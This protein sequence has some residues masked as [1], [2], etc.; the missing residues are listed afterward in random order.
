[1]SNTVMEKNS[2]TKDS[3]KS[4]IGSFALSV[5]IHGSVLF[6]V[7]GYVIF[8]GVLPKTPF[9]PVDG[10]SS[11]DFDES[12][13][14]EPSEI[15]DTMESPV[16]TDELSTE[17]TSQSQGEATSSDILVSTSPNNPSF[18]LS[19]AVGAPSYVPKIGFGGGGEKNTSTAT[20]PAPGK[21]IRSLFGTSEVTP[22][23]LVGSFFDIGR[24][25]KGRSRSR[26]E[27][28]AL[29]GRLAE[30]LV[31]ERGNSKVFDDV[32][33]STRKLY[34]SQFLFPRA[35]TAGAYEAFGEKPLTD[36]AS[37][38]VHYSARV[39]PPESGRYRFSGF[40]DDYVIVL[41]DGRPS[42]I[43]DNLV[44]ENNP[45]NAKLKS[46][47]RHFDWESPVDLFP[48]RWNKFCRYTMGDW[49]DW[50]KDETKRLDIFIGDSFGQFVAFVGI[51]Q[52]GKKYEQ[53]AD[54]VPI[55]PPFR[56][57]KQ[58]VDREEFTALL[59]EG[60]DFQE[61][62]GPVFISK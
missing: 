45:E 20:A 58:K 32:Y 2:P 26:D 35:T 62:G 34:A 49:I 41:V 56:L 21:V 22:N 15:P 33:E 61:R 31:K 54:G 30:E 19:P 29:A 28:I 47:K 57:D 60:V 52:E 38:W 53:T 59:R 55:L 10:V 50:K 8:E 46:T 5:I 27:A 12:V 3:A 25:R 36:F 18:T 13:L 14:P 37:F 42:V 24:D 6:L 4:A 9:S 40:G 1:M 23:A 17:T 39:S 51:E 48:L 16:S 7:G 43:A 11:S 44:H